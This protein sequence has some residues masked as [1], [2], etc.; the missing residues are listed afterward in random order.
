MNKKETISYWDSFWRKSRKQIEHGTVDPRE[1]FVAPI[2]L[3][4][5]IKMLDAGCGKGYSALYFACACDFLVG[6]DLSKRAIEYAH[7]EF[8]R[9]YENVDFIVGDLEHLPFKQDVFD[10]ILFADVLEHIFEQK[11]EIVLQGLLR[12]ISSKGQLFLTTPNGMYPTIFLRKILHVL[13]R[14]RL[15]SSVTQHVYDHPIFPR[16]LVKLIKHTGWKV[17]LYEGGSYRIPHTGYN[18]PKILLFAI[19]QFVIAVPS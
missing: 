3:Y 6:I 5:N 11:R 8:G 14:G 9:T 2:K 10:V 15:R 18:S 1:D 4:K 19:L 7:R 12:I 13:S 16:S 17:V